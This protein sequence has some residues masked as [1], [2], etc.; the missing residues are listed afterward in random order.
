MT[1]VN[2]IQPGGID[3]FLLCTPYCSTSYSTVHNY[4]R[5]TALACAYLIGIDAGLRRHICRGRPQAEVLPACLAIVK[6]HSG[7][8]TPSR[9]DV[10]RIV[11]I[12]LLGQPR[13]VSGASGGKGVRLQA[14]HFLKL[15]AWGWQLCCRNYY[16]GSNGSLQPAHNH[17]GTLTFAYSWTWR[18]FIRL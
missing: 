7:L 18:V 9:H 11:L 3:C 14:W 17:A 2:S 5:S 13:C 16:I 15:P 8:Q 12:L 6:I 4:M 1:E 10:W